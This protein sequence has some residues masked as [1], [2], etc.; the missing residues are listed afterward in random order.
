MKLLYVDLPFI[1]EKGG[2]KNRSNFIWSVLNQHFDCSLLLVK[3]WHNLTKPFP[4]AD[5]FD[6]Q[7]VAEKSNKLSAESIFKYRA[8][9]LKKFR[10]ILIEHQFDYIFFRFTSHAMLM[11]EAAKCS[12]TTKI[13]VD[14]DML[15]SRIADLS[16]EKNPTID[17]RYYFMER[18]K[19]RKFESQLFR[20]PYLFLFS[21]N[22]ERDS[23]IER[24]AEDLPPENY[25]ILPNTVHKTEIPERVSKQR[26]ILFFG[27]LNSVA[28]QDAI[29]NLSEN[30]YPHLHEYLVENDLIIDVVGKGPLE[31]MNVYY[32][33]RMNL[34]GPVDDIKQIISDAELIILPIR[35]ASGTRTRIL[36][37]GI[38]GKP[39]VT[40]SIGAEG[41]TFN[42]DEISII[43]DPKENAERII[44]F[45]DNPQEAKE[46]GLKLLKRCEEDYT[47]ESVGEKLNTMIRS[48]KENKVNQRFKIAIVTNRFYPEVGGAETNIYFQARELVLRGH[49]VTVFCPKRIERPHK[50][51]YDGIN[52]VRMPDLLDKEKSYPNIKTN[53]LCPEVFFGI[54]FG[55]FDV[56]MMFPAFSYNNLM[57][58]KAAKMS[59]K[60]T[61]LCSFDFLDYASII[62]E[63]GFV[64]KDA[65]DK[66]LPKIHHR[67]FMRYMDFIFAI[68]NKEIALYRK[69][70]KNVGYSPVPILLKE[71]DIEVENPRAKY[72]IKDEFV[73]L[74]LGRI[75]NIK[76]QDIALKAFVE[77]ADKIPEAKLVYVGRSDY[78]PDF[79]A[80]MRAII[81]NHNLDDRVIFT[82]MVERE[83]VLGWL[84]YSDIH[85]IPVR[86]MN[87]GA[88]VV[89][90]W[91]SGT[92]VLQ[93]DVVD[94]NLVIEE[95]NGYLFPS[96][97]VKVLSEKMVLAV[98]QKDKLDEMAKKGE[99]LVR[100]KYTYEYLCSLY[101]STFAAIQKR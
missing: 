78:E 60:P 79:I 77:V 99:K 5:S 18:F 28:N 44:H 26:R 2:D 21:N 47:W 87:S 88:V 40:T 85:V 6:Y 43:D 91:I 4:K 67:I 39:I 50:E 7:L 82:G 37:A 17:N 12:P 23:V 68:S 14:V 61:V 36:E 83:E 25:Q 8:D 80:E 32:K 81:K 66:A 42:E 71:Y 22:V 46:M 97:N 48:T 75:S 63:T 76:G 31:G 94:P 57:A 95:E 98:E 45:M 19:I 72:D 86:F 27:T 38:L 15:F 96:E 56:V 16:W 64:P 53:T 24:Y 33:E 65:L 20:K 3:T 51:V 52:V 62:K 73:F 92:P 13:I 55:R 69:F 74:S 100:E 30:I 9:Q 11:S 101:E 29:V 54:F 35:I 70:N 34:V 49:E 84:K 90:S 58:F 1:G 10:E 59:G 93:S 89:E 41:F